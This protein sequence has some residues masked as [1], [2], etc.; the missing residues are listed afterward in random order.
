[1]ISAQMNALVNGIISTEEQM[2]FFEE[3]EMNQAHVVSLEGLKR[4]H[5]YRAMD[6]GRHS[7]M[8]QCFVAENYHIEPMINIS[9]Q[10]PM[11]N[12]S[13]I[14][15][16]KMMHDKSASH[17]ES[18][19]SVAK[20]AFDENDHLLGGYLED[21]IADQSKELNEYYRIWSDCKRENADLNYISKELHCKYKHLE[22][23]KFG[24]TSTKKYKY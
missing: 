24:Y 2:R 21:M 15:A 10:T 14:D 6:R 3:H 7:L 8:L 18:L 12:L 13:L 4:F 5:R 1:M 17:I 11:N 9:Y 20:M 22:K 16:L 23:K 19:K